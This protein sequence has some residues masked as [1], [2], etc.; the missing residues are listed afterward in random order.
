VLEILQ[1]KEK[2]VVGDGISLDE[3][4]ELIGNTTVGCFCGKIIFP[5]LL[6]SWIDENWS[7]ILGYRPSFHTLTQGWI[8]FKFWAREDLNR[9]F[10]W[11][12]GWDPSKLV[13]DKL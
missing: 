8:Y 9:I 11:I 12:W 10:S 3:I 2:I 13:F 6:R 1:T 7:D 4:P 5:K